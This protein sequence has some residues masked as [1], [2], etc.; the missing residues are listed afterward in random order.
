MKLQP[1]IK[2]YLG[3]SK[4]DHSTMTMPQTVLILN[5]CR[6]NQHNSSLYMAT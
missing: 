5:S 4:V 6:T 2:P 1:Q 3:Y